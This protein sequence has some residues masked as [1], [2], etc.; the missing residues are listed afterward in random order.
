MNALIALRNA[1]LGAA[2]WAAILFGLD[3]WMD[4]PDGFLPITMFIFCGAG[5]VFS[6]VSSYN[7]LSRKSHLL[8]RGVEP[9]YLPAYHYFP[10]TKGNA[11]S[12]PVTAVFLFTADQL[13]VYEAD[14]SLCKD[15]KADLWGGLKKQL[16][17]VPFAQIEDA[18]VIVPEA[19]V[20]ERKL[21]VAGDFLVNQ[22]IGSA[23][24]VSNTTHYMGAYIV[25]HRI[26]GDP[27]VFGVSPKL[28]AE[29]ID[30]ESFLNGTVARGRAA[31]LGEADSLASLGLSLI[32]EPTSDQISIT[33]A[34][35]VANALKVRLAQS[36]LAP[37]SDITNVPNTGE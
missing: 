13:I 6:F 4:S 36:R 19:D 28:A 25:L 24:G 15:S 14:D 9:A 26:G 34:L 10:A 8:S 23:L 29:P 22:T 7:S 27:L 18:E 12:S 1:A 33:N 35:R 11:R 21:D 31:L 20:G 16:L 5:G 30:A 3:W 17:S 2:I 37:S 32:E